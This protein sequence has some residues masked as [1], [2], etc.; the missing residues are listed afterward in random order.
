LTTRLF[1]CGITIWLLAVAAFA[2]IPSPVPDALELLAAFQRGEVITRV[3]NTAFF[4]PWGQRSESLRYHWR[5]FS[6]FSFRMDTEHSALHIND[7]SFTL[8]NAFFTNGTHSDA[9]SAYLGDLDGI[10]LPHFQTADAVMLYYAINGDEGEINMTLKSRPYQNVDKGNAYAM[11]LIPTGTQP[12][13]NMISM[14]ITL[15]EDKITVDRLSFP[16]APNSYSLSSTFPIRKEL[17]GWIASTYF[18]AFDFVLIV[19]QTC[20]LLLGSGLIVV[21]GAVV[22]WY[23]AKVAFT[24]SSDHPETTTTRPA[25]FAEDVENYAEQPRSTEKRNVLRISI[26]E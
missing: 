12:L 10:N 1:L 20:G 6:A 18:A 26:K 15:H 17:Q 5:T 23:I 21:G 24:S 14:H 8:S 11:E 22:I 3:Y 2:A 16:P 4:I 19:G 9:I 7:A 25:D 13:E